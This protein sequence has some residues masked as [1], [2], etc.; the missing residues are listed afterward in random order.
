[1]FLQKRDGGRLVVGISDGFK[2]GQQAVEAFQVA[3]VD[4]V[5]ER[6]KGREREA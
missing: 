1:V 5:A 4:L 2:A 6:Q 3:S